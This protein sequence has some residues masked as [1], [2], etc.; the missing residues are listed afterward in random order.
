MNR[1]S[2]LRAN[3]WGFFDLQLNEHLFNTGKILL[4]RA[5]GIFPDGTVFN[6]NSE[7]NSLVLDIKPS[8][9]NK[10][11]YLALPIIARNSAEVSFNEEKNLITRYKSKK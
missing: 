11:V 2:K 4:E 7:E 1:T 9:M 5:S 10:V 3:N 8:Q 6:I